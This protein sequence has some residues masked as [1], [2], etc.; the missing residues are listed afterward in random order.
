MR[1]VIE[2]AGIKDIL[3]KSHGTNNPINTVRATP[4]RSS[5]S[6]CAAVAELRGKE[7]EQDRRQASCQRLAQLKARGAQATI[8]A[9]GE[10]QWRNQNVACSRAEEA[11]E[12]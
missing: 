12:G 2:T 10:H 9:T 11:R 1:A 8:A 6:H 5:S 7:V 4:R 3:T